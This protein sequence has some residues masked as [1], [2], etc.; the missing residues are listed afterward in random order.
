MKSES[1]F[2]LEPFDNVI[3]RKIQKLTLKDLPELRRGKISGE[4]AIS[5]KKRIS[6]L[7]NRSGGPNEYACYKGATLIRKTE[8]AEE[9]SLIEN[10][11]KDLNN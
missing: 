3:I 8:F 9:S 10:E 1:N 2:D 6:D 5:S 4:Y 11:I 7:I